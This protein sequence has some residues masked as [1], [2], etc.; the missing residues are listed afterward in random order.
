MNGKVRRLGARALLTLGTIAVAV[1]AG[2][3]VTPSS[4][5]SVEAIGD[6]LGAGGEFHSI[7]PERILDTR[8]ADLDVAPL[9]P[10]RTD[11]LAS[12][13]T[14]DVP[15]VGTAD[16]PTFADDDNDGFDDNVLAVVVNITVIEPT[17]I[18]YLRAFPAGADEGTTSVVN[19]L[20]DTNVPNTAVIRPGV[21]GEISLR[22]VTPQGRGS[23]DVAIDI[24]G[25]FS[26]SSYADRGARLIPIAPIRAFD[27]DLPLFGAQ[28]LGARSQIKIPIRGAADAQTPSVPVVPDD[29]DIIGAVVNVTGVNAFPG[30]VATY[31]SALPSRVPAGQKPSTSTV[32]LVPGQ[33]RANLAIVPVGADG[34]IHVFNLTGEVRLVVDIMGYLLKGEPQATRSGRVVPLVAPFRA[35]DTREPEFNSQPLGPGRAEDWSFDSFVQDVNIDGDPV[36]VQSGL[37]GNLTATNLQRQFSF[38]PVSS[39]MTV[40]PTPTGG[41]GQP[42]KVSNINIVEGD[43]VPNLALLRYGGDTADP[44]QLRFYNRAGY[45]DY[46]LDVYAVVLDD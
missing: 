11:P 42:P 14:F 1:A 34:S 9:G 18:G 23:A 30:S 38:A 16:I 44:F 5:R 19:F 22:L 13:R 43:T 28:T 6:P 25:W 32:N 46:L 3:V 41:D 17:R 24:S 12:S 31:L 39:F 2:V 45:V 7:T 40:Y 37:L 21:D 27:S 8:D 4:D 33:V 20:A 35:F 15:V 29:P 10:K 36:G 26:T